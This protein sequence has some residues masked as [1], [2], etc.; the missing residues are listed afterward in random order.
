MIE[1]KSLRVSLVYY[2]TPMHIF[3]RTIESLSESI[4]IAKKSSVLESCEVHVIQNKKGETKQI[5][6]MIESLKQLPCEFSLISNRENIG[7]GKA[8]NQAILSS[9]K[10]YHLVLN[11]DIELEKNSVLR[12]IRFLAENDE[13]S[14]IA[15]KGQ[16]KNGHPSHLCKSFP[17]VI[18]LFLRAMG[19][20]NHWFSPL[21][22]KYECHHLESS[23]EA[24]EVMITSGCF[25]LAKTNI[26]QRIQ[27]FDERFFLYFED[28]DLCLRLRKAGKI[29]FLPSV[30]VRHFGGNTF[31]KG[32]W[33]ISRFLKSGILFFNRYGWRFF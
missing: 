3:K 32:P 25:M 14:L 31:S 27:G 9:D 22:A 33:H 26:L 20:R 29:F 8:H 11:P 18:T 24:T 10:E 16:D 19:M 7:F 23:S 12:G 13:A 4:A 2:D 21:L 6:E 30:F 15:A 1:N 28:F 5:E 17:T